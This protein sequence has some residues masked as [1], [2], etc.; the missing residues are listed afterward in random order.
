[1]KPGAVS[2][3]DG[4]SEV[5]EVSVEGE[6]PGRSEPPSVGLTERTVVDRVIVGDRGAVGALFVHRVLQ[7]AASSYVLSRICAEQVRESRDI[8]SGDNNFCE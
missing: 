6:R 4:S 3:D 2:V 1:M 7:R 8:V 5:E